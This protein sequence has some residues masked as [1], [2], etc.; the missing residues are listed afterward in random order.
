MR[1]RRTSRSRPSA[2]EVR[3]LLLPLLEER[4]RALH[5]VSPRI[6]RSCFAAASHRWPCG[7]R[8]RA[9]AGREGPSALRSCS[10]ASA[11]TWGGGFG[12]SGFGG[13]GGGGRRS[14]ARRRRRLG[15]NRLC[16]LRGARVGLRDCGGGLRLAGSA[17]GGPPPRPT[18][19]PTLPSAGPSPRLRR[20]GAASSRGVLLHRGVHLVGVPGPAASGGFAVLA[21]VGPNER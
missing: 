5:G 21:Q 7:R 17:F 4:L 8:G 10:A 9:G 20:A 18:S 15:D 1:P 13:S 2:L 3:R 19:R 16:R 6:H 12:G 11:R 14:S